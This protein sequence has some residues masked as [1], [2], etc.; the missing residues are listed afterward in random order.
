MKKI[1]I[2]SIVLLVLVTTACDKFLGDN[3]SPNSP[4]SP[5]YSLVF[6]D[7]QASM[8]FYSNSDLFIW[9][10]IFTQQASGQGSATQTRFFDQYILTNSDVNNAFGYFYTESLTDAKYV[11][12]KSLADASPA[13]SGISRIMQAFMF[14]LQ[15]DAWG[16]IP[17]SDALKGLANT[18]PKYDDDKQI[19]D[20]LFVLIDKG[21]SEIDLP[22]KLKPSSDDLIYGGNLAKWKKFANTLKLR[23]A[24]HYAKIDNGA[25]LN[26]IINSNNDASFIASN[27][28]NCQMLFDNLT[29]RNNPIDQFEISRS[30][31]Y[32]PGEYIINLMNTKK[33]PR[34]V[35]YF[36][37]FPYKS[38]NYVGSPTLS[39]KSIDYSRINT[40]LRG[41]ITTDKREDLDSK[42]K[43]VQRDANGGTFNTAITYSGTAPIRLL[44]FS[45]YNFIRA[46]AALN[47]GASGDVKTYY[48][49]GIKASLDDAKNYLPNSTVYT[50][51]LATKY[52]STS[53]AYLADRTSILPITLKD[54]IEEKYVAEYGVSMEPWTDFRRTGFP[55][56]PVSPA[57]SAQGN[58]VLP[59]A[60]PYSLNEQTVNPNNVPARTSM[61]IKSIF[62]DK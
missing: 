62:W 27:S 7:T 20:S 32:F 53:K 29:N 16:K 6:S 9:S 14:S 59:R 21:I 28:E 4:I 23:L 11:I 58:N 25:I 51:I 3:V 54:I 5:N 48:T 41:N 61:A 37:D 10:S 26:S 1:Y 49:A 18:Q 47:Y 38:G 22:S 30:D 24:L 33:D 35:A 44:T 39:S 13:Y 15:V 45:E 34:R 31:Q 55:Q 56:I 8:A 2:F 52:D 36:T 43:P 50:P 42:G 17:Y 60:L 40:Y 19:Y 12:T 57:A 46:E